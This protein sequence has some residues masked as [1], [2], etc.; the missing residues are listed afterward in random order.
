MKSGTPHYRFGPY[1]LIP[2]E[3]VLKRDGES[4]HLTRKGFA[5]LVTLV[6]NAGHLLRKEEL[7]DRLWP[8]T[9]VEEGNLA[10]HV[11]MLRK[12]L[13]D[14]DDS[15]RYIETV[16]RIGFRFSAPVERI[17]PVPVV[18]ATASPV[19]VRSKSIPR[20]FY[21]LGITVTIATILLTAGVWAGRV[22]LGSS[23]DPG[24][25]WKALTVLPFTALGDEDV[26]R[27]GLGLT[28]GVISR[29]SVQSMI[30]VR[31]TSAVRRYAQADQ[32]D[33]VAVARSL[34]ADVALEGHIQRQG[35]ILRVS[36]QLLDVRTGSLVWAGTFDERVAALFEVEDAIAERVTAALRLRLAAVEQARLRRHY[37]KNAAAYLAYLQGR[38]DLMHH[39]QAATR[40]A[41]A[42]F[43]QALALDPNYTLARAGLAMAS[44]DMYLRFAPESELRLWGKRAEME[45]LRAIQLDPDLA[46]AHLARAAVLRKREFDWDET[47]ASSHR[48]LVLNPNLT[49]AHL[50]AA[51]ALYHLGL[52]E[53]SLAEMERGREAGDRIEPLRIEGLVALFSADFANARR[54]LEQVSQQS[55]RPI[56][57]TYLALAHY[58]SGDG[59][60]ARAMLEQLSAEPSASTSA[61]SRAALAGILA[62][63]GEHREARHLLN[64]LV[65]GTYQDHHVAYSIGAAF[66]QLGDPDRSLA[67]LRTSAEAGFPCDTWYARDPLLE[68]IRRDQRFV[69]FLAE[70]ATGRDA[71]LARYRAL[72]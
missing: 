28:D 52:M 45:A 7:Q 13:G 46:E 65:G 67:W 51:A 10:K 39:T 41:V 62:A 16:P 70:L 8:D 53:P 66:A 71:A 5:L 57:D 15:Q 49:Q 21:L 35:D 23:A 43:E 48:V 3:Q 69:S 47:I 68:P 55:S 44:A 38:A 50:F 34:G 6:E 42:A 26:G 22:R 56:G 4:I 9:V 11:S 60:R 25:R 30:R 59:A 20:V 12:A 36:V 63:S 54:H 40:R 33:T 58:Y 72:R 29:L 24:P 37:T 14:G 2:T 18:G 1:E 64:A 61:R 32:R 17:E 27:L 19:R 31:P